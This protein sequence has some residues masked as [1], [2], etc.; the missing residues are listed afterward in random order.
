LRLSVINPED[1]S[2]M[3][4]IFG[5]VAFSKSK[6]TPH[7]LTRATRDLF[8]LSESR[9]R[10]AAGL[11]R[12]S[13]SDFHILKGSLSPSELIRSKPFQ[14]LSRA[15]LR[16]HEYA[17]SSIC[18]VGH[19]RLVTNG[20]LADNRNNQP[21]TSGNV[22]GV[23]NGIIVNHA[24]LWRSHPKLS[25]QYDVDSEIICALLDYYFKKYKS[26][27]Q[28]LSKTFS[29]IEG[30]ASIACALTNFPYLLLGTN[31]GSLYLSYSFTHHIAVFASEEYLVRTFIAKDYVKHVF[32]S[33][34]ITQLKA[35]EGCIIG[36]DDFD[37]HHVLVSDRHS[38]TAVLK[39]EPRVY[40]LTD[41]SLYPPLAAPAVADLSSAACEVY[42][43]DFEKIAALRRCSRCVLPETM[44]FIRFDAEGVCNYCHAYKKITPHGVD[45][46]RKKIAEVSTTDGRPDCLVAL[47]GGR[48]SCY[49]LH[50]VKEE[51]GLNPIAYTYDWGMVTDLA[52]RN[53][54][55]MCGRLGVEHIIVS[56][57]ITRKRAHIRA[58]ILAWL[59]KP[60]LGMIPLF[61]AGDKQFFY[62]A[63]ELMKHT[64]VS[65]MVFSEN[66]LEKTDF[67]MGFCAINTAGHA[68]ERTHTLYFT[69]FLSKLQIAFYYAWQFLQNPA[70]LNRSLCDTVSAYVS[71]YFI[72]HE[73]LLLF[74]Y[75]PW[76]EKKTVSTLIDRY[77]WEVSPD[78]A[79]TWRIGDG[80]AAFYNYL[81]LRMAGFTENDTFR[82]NQIREGLLDRPKALELVYEENRPRFQS[83]CEYFRLV[84]I[85]C[86]RALKKINAVSRF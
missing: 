60:A 36:L 51:L 11:F 64:G 5:L 84:D 12:V 14:E 43:P 32:R 42:Q 74:E 9:G 8:R 7:D 31:T 47:S 82:S 22:I 69:P 38:N 34:E 77:G 49:G 68:H 35:Q 75:I 56:A 3:C 17:D 13:L 62:H 24:E 19:S 44:P 37:C 78:T 48:D 85:D 70:Y 26:L 33:Q 1:T 46:L 20:S 79:S 80:T 39:E 59:K 71:T 72:P 58:N 27:H 73:Y 30:T 4:G 52:R 16:F 21:I 76:D 41:H 10:E 61:M 55:R 28:A 81:Y 23:H 63:N 86:A 83:L 65:T 25:R 40:S 50:Y 2:A 67:K 18:I 66:K 6:L 29:L 53:Q 57:D 45:P 15:Y 54:A